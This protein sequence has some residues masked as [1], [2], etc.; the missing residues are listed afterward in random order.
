MKKN[1]MQDVI[2]P[3]QKRSIRDIPLPSSKNHQPVAETSN[4]I[5]ITPKSKAQAPVPKQTPPPQPPTEES[6]DNFDYDDDQGSGKKKW[7]IAGGII[8]LVILI[9]FFSRSSAEI[10]VFPKQ[11]KVFVQNSYEIYDENLTEKE[12]ALAYKLLKIQKD[13]SVEVEPSGEEN[14]S[15]KASGLI[16]IF[17]EY[18]SEDQK[19]VERTRF[20]T[21]KGQIYRIAESITV[22]GYTKSGDEIVPGSIDVE[23]FA[24]ET[25]DDYNTGKEDFTIPGFEGLPQ[26]DTMY[27]KSVSDITGGFEGVK[28]VV[29]EEDKSSA[30][31]DLK[32]TSKE[33]IIEEI[34]NSSDEFVI[35]FDE[36]DIE[37]SK[38]TENEIKNGVELKLAASV[39]AYVFDSK[40]LARF[41]ADKNIPSAP[42]GN[43]SIK[44][45]GDLD[46]EIISVDILDEDEEVTGTKTELSIESDIELEWIIDAD[47]LTRKLEG[48]SRNDFTSLISEFGEISRADAKLS[49]FWKNSFPKAAKIEILIEK[50]ID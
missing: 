10:N 18:S 9:I 32:K 17:N 35:I 16:T 26:F 27:A 21:K 6:F 14:V 48:K 4:D 29:S 8:L 49:P 13:A 31:E 5:K 12:D 1:F 19:L 40:D 39:N 33:Q 36:E 7:F 24:D 22:P 20:E 2:P 46:L 44:N 28:K 45:T 3:T 38:L 41:I 50:Y 15:E 25:G 34:N 37:Y 47:E 43:I 11:E 30:L 23:V 42:E